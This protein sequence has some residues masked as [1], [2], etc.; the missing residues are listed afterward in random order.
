M[1]QNLEVTVV[2]FSVGDEAFLGVRILFK[3][4]R[5]ALVIAV[6]VE[7]PVSIQLMLPGLDG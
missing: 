6:S 5:I 1:A 4:L 3:P 7:K 2:Q